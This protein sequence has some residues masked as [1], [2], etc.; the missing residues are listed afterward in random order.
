MD[1]PDLAD[2]IQRH[3]QAFLIFNRHK[4]AHSLEGFSE[5]ERA[6]FTLI[7]YMLHTNEPRCF[8]FVEDQP[9]PAGIFG[10]RFESA[11]REIGQNYFPKDRFIPSAPTALPIEFLALVGSVGSVGYTA[12]SDFDYW[13]CVRESLNST[14]EQ[15]LK[16]KLAG[17]EAW[18]LETLDVEVHFF[19]TT[20]TKL[21][22]N[23]FGAVSGESCGSALG[24]LL[25]EEFYRGSLHVAGKIPVWWLVPA[26]A[27]EEA[28]AA[29]RAWLRDRPELINEFI[30]IG[31]IAAIPMEEMIG[32]GLW[33]INKGVES[34]FKS[35]IKMALLMEY[36]E[37]GGRGDHIADVLKRLVQVHPDRLE[38]LDAYQLMV[39]R[40][41]DYFARTG[42]AEAVK[43]LRVCFFLKV[44][45]R[46][47]R[48]WRSPN[49]PPR[50]VD[51]LLLDYCRQWEWSE[52]DVERWESWADL[53]I[54]DAI[55]LKSALEQFMLS[56]VRFLQQRCAGLPAA[57]ALAPQDFL[58]LMMRLKAIY[59][60]GGDGIER[61]YPPY[62]GFLR[63]EAYTLRF[64]TAHGWHQQRWKLYRG[65]H[66]LRGT[67][68]RF[69]EGFLIR[70]HAELPQLAGWMLA[71]DLI[72]SKTQFSVSLPE[73]DRFARNLRALAHLF[74]RHFGRRRT[75]SLDLEAFANA[76][77]CD[78]F[79][80]C[81]NLL[82][83]SDLGLKAEFF[84]A[85]SAPVEEQ[86]GVDFA[87]SGF[88]APSEDGS[89]RAGF[90][91]GE[92]GGEA[93]ISR[94]IT[95]MLGPRQPAPPPTP[96]TT[97]APE[98]PIH[99]TGKVSTAPRKAAQRLRAGEDPLN[100]GQE[101]A[102]LLSEA[103]LIEMND[104]NEFIL[105]SFRGRGWLAKVATRLCQHA[106]AHG[107][108]LAEVLRAFVARWHHDPRLMQPRLLQVI[109][110]TAGQLLGSAAPPGSTPGEIAVP[111]YLFEMG[112]EPQL[113]WREGLQVRCAVLHDWTHALGYLSLQ[114]PGCSREP[115]LD[116]LTVLYALQQ[117]VTALAPE[118]CV[119]VFISTQGRGA[120][121]AIVDEARNFLP[122]RLELS[123]LRVFLPRLVH[124]LLLCHPGAAAN[125][126]PSPLRVG[127]VVLKDDGAHEF[128]DLT[129]RSLEVVRPS[130]ARLTPLGLRLP[131]REARDFLE[132]YALEGR[133]LFSA[134]T[135]GRFD[136]LVTRLRELRKNHLE[137]GADPYRVMLTGHVL[138]E[139][140]TREF[141]PTTLSRF[142]LKYSLEEALT[143]AIY[144]SDPPPNRGGFAVEQPWLEKP[145]GGNPPRKAALP[146]DP[147]A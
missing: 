94:I 9:A 114:Q 104:W 46:V 84:R 115:R 69:E 53:P 2:A 73:G 19:L 68:G 42:D 7:P 105:H 52:A 51:A 139:E 47:H 142:F 35:A 107:L 88:L 50:E 125:A 62:D 122:L 3:H 87:V 65:H 71:N 121:I 37:D 34:P 108:E 40:V 13:C 43:L 27:G 33:Q 41:L 98:A 21:R 97:V 49:R 112:G 85:S 25:K 32:G 23:D 141:F 14:E 120:V 96:V 146:E 145:D 17:I 140:G 144:P 63:S 61:F 22:A 113:L 31:H 138:E 10:Y 79:L 117:A 24:K 30:D 135:A 55:G 130:I 109:Q 99:G 134:T 11:V 116:R 74:H 147:E 126:P 12:Q 95:S 86:P 70:E 123:E 143:A 28:Y 38:H 133:C 75:T 8:G 6:A 44:K 80:L 76:P 83:G 45:P 102:S 131:A 101:H 118:K 20:A 58:K 15:R 56:G 106:L 57:P 26:G 90:A 64:V 89:E 1:A 67:F 18:C 72:G 81:V 100:A 137:K 66:D 127:W 78:R 39:D 92:G 93:E 48:W 54:R 128:R 16:T 111:A 110:D 119:S 129:A 132:R 103:L 60:W 82:P 136:A 59:G 124:G 4:K 29:V 36:A 91:P 5:A 77:R